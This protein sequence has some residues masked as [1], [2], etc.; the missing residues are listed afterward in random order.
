MI[1]M[2]ILSQAFNEEGAETLQELPKSFVGY[3]KEKV[4]RTNI[5]LR[6]IINVLIFIAMKIVV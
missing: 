3:G 6:N 4:Q 2:L 1:Y 5:N